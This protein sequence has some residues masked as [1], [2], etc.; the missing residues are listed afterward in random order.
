MEAN[1]SPANS[2]HKERQEAALERFVGVARYNG[3]V[4]RQERAEGPWRGRSSDHRLVPDWAVRQLVTQ[5]RFQLG[6]DRDG[7][8]VAR[9]HR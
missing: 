7:R 2:R 5:G 4:L 3:G 1:V 9:H 8:R 6:T